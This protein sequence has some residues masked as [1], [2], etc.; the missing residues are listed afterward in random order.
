[1]ISLWELLVVN[2]FQSFWLAVLGLVVLFYIILTIG[3]VSQVT[4]LNFLTIFILAMAMGYGF[5]LISIL[6]TMLVLVMH[7][8]AIPRL[9]NS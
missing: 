3:K 5:S 8:L 1:M 6:V 9:L 4:I 7:L 2:M